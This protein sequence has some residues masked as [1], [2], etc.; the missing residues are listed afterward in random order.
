M[1]AFLITEAEEIQIMEELLILA[2][3]QM[4]IAEQ[5]EAELLIQD[6]NLEDVLKLETMHGLIDHLCEETALL[7]GQITTQ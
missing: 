3:D 1:M 5:T 7:A 6:L 2:V 4:L